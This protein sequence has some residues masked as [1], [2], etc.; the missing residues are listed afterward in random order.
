M[1]IADIWI[2]GCLKKLLHI[3]LR[4]QESH[5]W[6]KNITNI[7]YTMILTKDHI[8]WEKY[9]VKQ[10]FG[11]FPS[12]VQMENHINREHSVPIHIHIK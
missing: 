8:M 1:K 7:F 2:I 4:L 12:T 3:V 11:P 9:H 10:E 5:K 6:R